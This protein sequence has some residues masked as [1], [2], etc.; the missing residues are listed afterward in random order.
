MNKQATMNK[1][2]RSIDQG[3][4][5]VLCDDLCDNIE[6]LLDAFELEY[7]TNSKMISMS[8]PIHGGDNPSAVNIYPEGESYRGNWKCRTHNCEQEFKSSIIGFVRGIISHQKYNWSEAGDP[9]CSFNEALEYVQSFLNKDLSS[10]KI[11]KSEKEKKNFTNIINYI[12]NKIEK[13]EN[14]IS[15]SQIIKSIQIPAEYY[16][17][18]NYSKEVLT[19]YDVGLCNNPSKPMYNRVVVPIYDNDYKYMVGCTCRS[20]FEKCDSCGSYHDPILTCPQ[21]DQR[22]LFPKWKHSTELKSQ[23]YLY[24]FWFAKQYIYESGLA[25]IVESPGNVWRLEENG[26]HNSVAM[27]GSSLSDRQKIL[28]DS[29]GAMTLI[30]LTDNDD[31]GRKAANQIKNKCQNTYRIFIPTINKNDVGE[32]TPEEIETHIKQY[33]QRIV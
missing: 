14:Q 6:K 33:V 18:R 4:L 29:S 13:P 17:H 21:N 10:I 1:K 7:K 9:T 16:V 15:R 28:L 31:A 5:K 11:S 24:N 26:I 22:W 23:N 2:Y 30:I 25:I 27:F 20:I 19:K 12:Q 8:C 32:M 3:K